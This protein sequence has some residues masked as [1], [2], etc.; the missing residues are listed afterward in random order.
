MSFKVGTK[1]RVIYPDIAGGYIPVSTVGIAV[2]N[3][4]LVEFDNWNSGHNCDNPD[5]PNN[6][7]WVCGF[8]D[9]FEVIEEP[10]SDFYVPTIWE[11]LEKDKLTK[12]GHPRFYKLTEE[13][14]EVHSRKNYDY[15]HG[16]RPLGNFERRAAILALYP[17]LDLSDPVVIAVIDIF[18]QLDAAMWMLNSSHESKNSEDFGTRMGD[19]SIYAKLSRILWEERSQK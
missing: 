3:R 5:G 16:G 10:D 7:W 8:E 18:K 1:I 13:E 17:N 11:M 19:V 2:N 12:Y 9:C 4:G 14:N 6:R 15:A